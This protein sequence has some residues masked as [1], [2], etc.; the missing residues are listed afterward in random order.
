MPSQTNIFR[1]NNDI[2]NSFQIQMPNGFFLSYL[3][4]NV[5]I[6]FKKCNIYDPNWCIANLQAIH[7]ENE[8]L[9]WSNSNLSNSK[10][11]EIRKIS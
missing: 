7:F 1:W 6:G 10:F 3:T 5:L 9:K 11:L 8:T 2:S 4:E